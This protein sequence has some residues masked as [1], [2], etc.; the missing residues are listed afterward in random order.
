LQE[1]I[2]KLWNSYG[3]EINRVFGF[4]GFISGEP[5][6]RL[7]QNNDK[8]KAEEFI[9]YVVEQIEILKDTNR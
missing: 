2:I 9:K 3:S 4:N 7:F 6:E 8:L 5:L 1:K